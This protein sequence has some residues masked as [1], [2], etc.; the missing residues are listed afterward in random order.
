[1]ENEKKSSA[2]TS[3]GTRLSSSQEKQLA[4]INARWGMKKTVTKSKKDKGDG[5]KGRKG[6]NKNAE[7]NGKKV[8]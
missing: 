2:V 8:A 7:K 1:M 6:D 3:A 4:E 5:K